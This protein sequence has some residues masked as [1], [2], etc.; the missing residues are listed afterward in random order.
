MKTFILLAGLLAAWVA[1]AASHADPAFEGVVECVHEVV[2]PPTTPLDGV[3][4]HSVRP[5]T[6]EQL[7]V[8]L[9]DGRTLLTPVH[10][11]ATRVRPGE[12]VRLRASPRG[13]SVEPVWN[14]VLPM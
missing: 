13:V 8:Q 9:D 7:V 10:E 6:G 3:L 11:S 2:L 5:Q 4:E 1:P 14:G 12:R